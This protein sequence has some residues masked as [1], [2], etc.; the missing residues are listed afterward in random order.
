MYCNTLCTRPLGDKRILF[1]VGLVLILAE[2][3]IAGI[4]NRAGLGSIGMN[5][6]NLNV[7]DVFLLKNLKVYRKGSLD[8]SF[9]F[10]CTQHSDSPTNVI[11]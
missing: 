2:V 4:S 6:V 1:A 8:C 3:Q 11:S 10:L 5:D 7:I 9:K